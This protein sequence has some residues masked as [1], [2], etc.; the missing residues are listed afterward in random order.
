MTASG[1]AC[2]ADAKSTAVCRGSAGICDV[3][4]TCD[5]ITDNCPADAFQPA[6][7]VCRASADICD[8]A[9]TCTGSSAAC[10]ADTGQPDGDSDTVC[11]AI[12]NCDTIANTDQANNDSDSFGDA[13]DPCTNIVPT[14]PSKTK[15]ILSKI[16]AP[17][18]DDKLN[19]KG[20][21]TAVPNS[22]TVDPVTNGLRV[23]VSDSLGNT[24]IDVT[25]PGGAYNPATKIGWKVNGS[26]TA[27]KYK[28]ST[29]PVNGLYKAQLK[30]Y[31]STPGKYKFAVKGKNGNYAVNTANLPLKGTLVIDVPYA[32]TG[33]CGETAFQTPPT[34]PNCSL[35]GGG[36]N[37][38]C[39]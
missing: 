30:A 4:E 21:F 34:K 37:V 1:V 5:G 13:C 14:V 16:L 28:N 8:I 17:T 20:F 19:F 2:P 29:S 6:S 10:P 35:T 12:D 22:P 27:W 11:D 39:K 25:I 36:K 15:L 3:A 23:L 9:E 33:Q 18:T 24:P 26:G 31:S 32:E 38:K 7:T